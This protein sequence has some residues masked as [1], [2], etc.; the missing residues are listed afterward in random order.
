ME[1]SPKDAKIPAE[2]ALWYREQWELDPEHDDLARKAIEMARKVQTLDPE[3]R[4]GYYL[5]FSLQQGRAERFPKKANE[6]RHLALQ[7]APGSRRTRSDGGQPTLRTR[8]T[9]LQPSRRRGRQ[10]RG[11]SRTRI[12]RTFPYPRAHLD[13]PEGRDTPPAPRPSPVS[14]ASCEQPVTHCARLLVT[15]NQLKRAGF[16]PSIQTPTNTCRNVYMVPAG[17][18]LRADRGFEKRHGQ[19]AIQ[20]RTVVLQLRTVGTR[21]Q[22]DLERSC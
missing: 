4:D 8:S 18:L 21:R 17:V 3:S 13:R 7:A 14:V 12:E 9:P 1:L 19:L 22:D 5:E 6:C 11:S 20:R 15:P 2:L 10:S 16:I